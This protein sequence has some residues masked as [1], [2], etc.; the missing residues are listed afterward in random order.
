MLREVQ[1][2]RFCNTGAAGAMR[3]LSCTSATRLGLDCLP[4]LSKSAC[5]HVFIAH[6][7]QLGLPTNALQVGGLHVLAG[8]TSPLLCGCYM[9]C[10]GW[11]CCCSVLCCLLFV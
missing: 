7:R 1:V 10:Q 8:S 11:G 6:V 5:C 4:Q 2:V 3:G 9:I